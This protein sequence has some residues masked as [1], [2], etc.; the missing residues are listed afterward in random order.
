MNV[1]VVGYSGPIDRSPVKELADKI[2]ELGRELVRHGHIVLNG[3]RDGVMEL[4]SKAASEAGGTVIGVLPAFESGNDYLTYKVKTPFDNVTRSVVLVESCD[5][6]V[7]IGGEVGTAIEVLLAYAKFKPIILFAGTG[8]WT[9]RFAS[10]AIDGKYL[11]NRKNVE[12]RKASSVSEIIAII[13]EIG[14]I[15]HE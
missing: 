11:D 7:S 14:R 1:A 3:G 15:Q 2:V 6:L 13:D 4:V 12:I 10:V 8:G 9:D 5:V